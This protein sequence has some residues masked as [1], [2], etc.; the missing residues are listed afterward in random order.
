MSNDID[1]NLN[2]TNLND[3]E[4]ELPAANSESDK[5]NIQ[6]EE[7]VESEIAKNRLNTF[8]S[9]FIYALFL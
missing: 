2:D 4:D 9:V 5:N 6:T 7:P 1:T 8:R 3:Q